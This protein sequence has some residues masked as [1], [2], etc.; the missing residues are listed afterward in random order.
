[1]IPPPTDPELVAFAVATAREAGSLTLAW[2][3][4]HNLEIDHKDDGSPVT[5]ARMPGSTA[6]AARAS[7]S[8]RP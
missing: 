1:M 4:R 5:A 3:Q 2:F 8:P 7:R 6:S